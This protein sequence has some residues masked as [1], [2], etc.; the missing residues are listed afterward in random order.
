[1]PNTSDAEDTLAFQMRAVGI[2][3]TRQHRFAPPRRWTADFLVAGAVLVEVEGGA[4]NG[5][6]KRGTA[7]DTDYEKFNQA[8]L[9]GWT[10]LR[11]STAMVQ[12]GS[13]LA[14]IEAALQTKAAK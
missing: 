12:A 3:F 6:H 13:A 2:E 8:N 11:F 10:V 9:D 14:T 4:W 7:A 5:G 1:M